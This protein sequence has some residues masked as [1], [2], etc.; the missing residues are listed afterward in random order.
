MSYYT[1][2]KTIS[3]K[4]SPNSELKELMKTFTKMV[5]HCLKIGIKENVTNMKRLS[6]LC[7]HELDKYDILSSY[8]LNAIS[9]AAGILKN[10][11]Q[12]I[13]RGIKTKN[14]VVNHGFLAN[15]YG[16]KMN[17]YLLTIP[18]KPREPV[19]ILLNDHTYNMLKSDPCLQVKSFTM[20]DHNLG[21]CISKEVEE[22]ECTDVVG[23]DRNLRNVTC[24]NEKEVDFY[25][26]NKLV[27]FKENTILARS[28]FKRNDIRK[29]GQFYKER[30]R[31]LTNRTK[32]YLHKISKKIVEKAIKQKTAI[33]VEDL[34]GIRKMY[35][36]GNGQGKKSR[37]KMNNNWPFFEL[38]RQI[39]YKAQWAGIPFTKI[40]PKNTSQLCPQCGKRLQED[41]RQLS[42]Q[43][44][45]S[46]I[47]CGLFMNR[48]I[49]AAMNISRKLS[50]RF[51]DSRGDADEAQC[52]AFE[53]PMMES[54]K[55][56]IRI[57]DVS[58][59]NNDQVTSH[60]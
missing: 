17:G 57:V 30:Q 27:I 52:R 6:S 50:P 37:R 44:K 25:K 21:I 47:N 51:R 29:K 38:Q 28:G 2:H 36:K 15:C 11:E 32:Q 24:G 45:K 8:K 34:K 9:R 43:R 58:K 33:A 26:T 55:P 22:I 13:K 7:Y 35:R 60:N 10:R 14:P 20:T 1:A 23:I 40:N 3:Q 53:R 5:N 39:E 42:L 59:C 4:Y 19:N 48:D 46:C 41:T 49:I 31:R 18:F 54:I 56:V 16:V 12:S